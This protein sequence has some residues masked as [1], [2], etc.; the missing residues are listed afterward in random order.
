MHAVDVEFTCDGDLR[1]SAEV[2]AEF[3]PS[4]SLVAVTRDGELWLLPLVGSASGGLALKQRNLR[5]D[6]SAL[7]REALPDTHP[8]GRAEAVWDPGNAALRVSLVGSR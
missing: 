7:V 8:V 6:R 3:F 1:I 4:G 2:A 5:G